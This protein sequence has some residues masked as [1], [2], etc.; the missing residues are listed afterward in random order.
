MPS[1]LHTPQPPVTRDDRTAP[2]RDHARRTVR[3][4]PRRKPL[5][6]Q[7]VLALQGHRS[8]P[9]V[10][11]LMT[12]RPGP[13]PD[14]ADVARFDALVAEA[15]E[16]LRT[17][18][19]PMAATVVRALDEV[20]GLEGPVERAV[21]VYVSPGLVARVDLPV[22]VVDR[23]V[24]D[25]T[26]ATRDLVRALHRTPRHVVLVLT[27]DTARIFDGAGDTLTPVRPGYP[28]ADLQH[29]PGDPPGLAFQ[30]TVDKALGAHLRV[31]PAPLVLVGPEPALSSF[32][33]M[34][35]NTGRLAGTIRTDRFDEVGAELRDRVRE[36]LER[37]LHSRREEALELLAKRTDEGRALVGIQ[38]AWTGARWE[39]PEMLM[40]EESFYYPARLGDGAETLV[41]ASDPHAPDVIDDVV[42]ELI[43][44]VLARGGWIALLDDG[45]LPD[46]AGVA[47][48]LR[49]R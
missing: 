30:T 38:E 23:S 22:E 39:R 4:V 47:L 20:T 12:T 31:H 25:P 44:L 37:Y 1:E 46:G 5:T 27:D 43:E 17:E 40:V 41:P 33:W 6:P 32:R 8:Y 35:R 15:Q 26:F 42:D 2:D 48:T 11:L 7:T 21:A 24:V 36:V 18:L 16:R 28:L 14:P 45:M 29:R 13:E 3:R 49:R 19:P 10:S 9:S 34:S